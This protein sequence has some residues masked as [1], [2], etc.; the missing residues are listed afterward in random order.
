MRI[1]G[2]G[3]KRPDGKMRTDKR[4]HRSNHVGR[5]IQPQRR[6]CEALLCGDLAQ[7]LL[8][9]FPA[10]V[11]GSAHSQSKSE[12]TGCATQAIY[13][14]RQENGIQTHTNKRSANHLAQL[15]QLLG[16]LG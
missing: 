4:T 3:G 5:E 1:G 6:G 2:G 14:H 9:N 10:G 8:I 16:R 15:A 7:F 12:K 11:P 13:P